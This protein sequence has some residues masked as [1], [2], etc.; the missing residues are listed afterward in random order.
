LSRLTILHGIGRLE[1]GGV[2][3]YLLDFVPAAREMGV[4]SHLVTLFEREPGSLTQDFERLGCKVFSSHALRSRAKM[5]SSLRRAAEIL[6]PDI[7][8]SH[9]G[10]LSGDFVVGLRGRVEKLAV[11]AHDLGGLTPGWLAPYRALS[12]RRVLRFSDRLLAVS[13]EAGRRLVGSSGRRSSIV[14]VGLDLKSWKPDATARG[15]IRE[16]L[17]VPEGAALMLHVGRFVPVKNHP[18]LIDLAR[19]LRERGIPFVMAFAGDGPELEAIRTLAGPD[20]RLRFLGARGDIAAFMSAADLLL[21]PSLSE[22]TPRVLMEAS[23]LGLPFLATSNA[24]LDELFPAAC[25]LSINDSGKWVEAINDLLAKP[26]PVRPL[27]D[28]SIER[29]VRQTL[30][31]LS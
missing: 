1:I 18:F 5:F 29:A 26:E 15:R 22:G 16:D 30:E 25:R 20:D 28:L 2:E 6:K 23:A 17:G 19:R 8:L 21:L 24:D 10:E 7:A 14:P 31:A 11:H 27:I 13:G 9:M 3:R 4:E 12:R